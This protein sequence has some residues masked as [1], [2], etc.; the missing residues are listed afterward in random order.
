M[1][2]PQQEATKG[3]RRSARKPRQTDS[4]GGAAYLSP[5]PGAE[6]VSTPDPQDSAPSPGTRNTHSD[7]G[8]A[9]QRK[10]SHVN[11]KKQPSEDI[12]QDR[13][14]PSNAYA[15]KTKATPIKQAYAGPTFHQS[16]AASALPIP[17]FYSKSVP[18]ASLMPT[19]DPPKNVPVDQSSTTAA[20]MEDSPSKRE[21]T[22]L[23]FLF[24]AARQARG[25]TPCGASP[26]SRSGNISVPAG[27]PASRSPAPRDGDPLFPFELEGG[28]I[29]GEDGSAFATPY[30]D[31]IEALRSTRPSASLG[32]R[33]MNENE[34]KAKTEALKKLLM[35]SSNQ[36]NGI[37]DAP[38]TEE[39]NNPF[40]A[41]PPPSFSNFEA[42]RPSHTRHI[43]GPASPIYM[44]YTTH[45]GS[46]SYFNS[47][48]YQMSAGPSQ[49][50][51]RPPSSSLRN[52]YG[53][54]SD[55]EPAELSS[56]NAIM[57]PISTAR[58]Q[59][60]QHQTPQDG[61]HSQDETVVHPNPTPI[62]PSKH[63]AQ[64]LE[65]DLRR[66]L[67]LDLTSRG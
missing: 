36:H 60:R 58:R 32:P 42:P 46:P 53:A 44:N 21:S 54:V 17:S 22:P 16:P 38:R 37:H 34:R 47:V 12:P 41:R 56:D 10:R 43:S 9:Q 6:D 65:D 27:S 45:K 48:S 28:G 66:V 63:T 59:T 39:T 67:K 23:D 8:K 5:P 1:S 55:P 19:S 35:N 29:P 40:N 15:E 25:G 62:R 33:S 11:N 2:T 64:Q 20:A 30:K 4:P 51:K 18:T 7:D 49:T 31:R 13:M 52:V 24:E 3:P 50:P 61:Y 26:N 14:K 57:S